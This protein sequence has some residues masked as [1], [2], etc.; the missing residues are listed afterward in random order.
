MTF[1][2][3][4]LHLNNVMLWKAEWCAIL[5]I[6]KPLENKARTGPRSAARFKPEVHQ[7]SKLIKC[8]EQEQHQQDQLK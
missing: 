4:E 1:E 3:L 2:W 6:I 5:K 8:P 7:R